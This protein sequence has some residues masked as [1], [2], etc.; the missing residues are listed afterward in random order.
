MPVTVIKKQEWGLFYYYFQ[1]YCTSAELVQAA[2][3]AAQEPFERAITVLDLLQGELDMEKRDIDKIIALNK[4]LFQSGKVT[5][6]AAILTQNRTLEIFVKAFELLSINET[7]KLSSFS[8]LKEGLAWL[9]LA[10]HEQELRKV[11]DDVP[12]M[13]TVQREGDPSAR[14]VFF[15]K[16][17][18]PHV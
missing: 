2:E 6:H 14:R 3:G 11:L 15:D 10:E 7:T 17:I 1:G 13:Q 5:T 4:R 8:S 16:A 12:A 9:G 18:E